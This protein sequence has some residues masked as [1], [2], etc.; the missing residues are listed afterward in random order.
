MSFRRAD[1]MHHLGIGSE[2]RGKRVLALA[3]ADDHT[4][5]VIHLDTGEIIATN[6]IDPTRTYWRNTQKEP[7]RWPSSF[8]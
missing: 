3:L 2:H 8:S 6:T 1:R 7:G 4:I 5:T